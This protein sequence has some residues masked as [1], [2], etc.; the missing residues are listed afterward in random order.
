[1]DASTTTRR[2]ACSASIARL[3]GSS[4]CSTRTDTWATRA[5]SARKQ[6]P[7]PAAAASSRSTTAALIRCPLLAGT[8]DRS[9]MRSA[10]WKAIPRTRPTS[11]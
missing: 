1:M 5:R 4:S 9:A 10:V 8:P 7:P 6:C 11:W 2:S 3:I